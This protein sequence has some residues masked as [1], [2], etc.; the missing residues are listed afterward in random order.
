MIRTSHVLG[1]FVASSLAGLLFASPVSAELVTNGGF[2]TGTTGWTLSGTDDFTLTAA[3]QRSLPALRSASTARN[4]T[5]SSLMVS[6]G[7]RTALRSPTTGA[8]TS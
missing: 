2:D 4:S 1:L 6:R 5:S 8:V 3:I 7:R